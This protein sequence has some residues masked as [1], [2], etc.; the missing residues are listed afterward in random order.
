MMGSATHIVGNRVTYI[1]ILIELAL[2]DRFRPNCGLLG[3]LKHLRLVFSK[4]FCV[5]KNYNSTTV[6]NI[7]SYDY[8]LILING[9]HNW[10]ETGR[11]ILIQLKL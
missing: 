2:R 9:V 6:L 10:D 5:A 1:I 4:V 11:V 7:A 3:V 8:L